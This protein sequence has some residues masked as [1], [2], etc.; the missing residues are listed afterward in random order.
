MGQVGVG[1][2][3]TETVAEH[4]GIAELVLNLE[5]H[6]L[7]LLAYN[8]EGSGDPTLFGVVLDLVNHELESDVVSKAVGIDL[9]H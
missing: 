9:N 1:G 2:I 7:T 5:G 4:T 8:L 6:D 3:H